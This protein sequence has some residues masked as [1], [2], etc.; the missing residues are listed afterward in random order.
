[1]GRDIFISHQSEFKPWV[2]WLAEA[3]QAQ[4]RTVFFDK[5]HLVAGETWVEGLDRGLQQARAAVLVATPEAVNSGWVR[6]EHA[7]LMSRCTTDPAFHYVPLVFGRFPSLPFLDTLHCVDC[8]E[9]SQYRDWFH[10]LC[11]GLDGV[12]PAD[13][14]A[15]YPGLK[16]PPAPA[17]PM[18]KAEAPAEV[19]FVQQ[20]MQQL[21]LATSPPVMVTSQGRRHQGAVVAMLRARAIER[22]GTAGVVHAVP[23]CSADAS[24]SAC[25]ADLGR[26]CKLDGPTPD[27]LSFDAAMERRIDAAGRLFLLLTG[28]ENAHAT[29]RHEL[30]ACLRTL[31]SHRPDDLRVALVGGERLVEQGFGNGQHSFLSGSRVMAWPHPTVADVMAWQSA[32]FPD[33][34]LPEDQAT[35]LLDATGGH[36]SLVRHGLE[37]WADR[38]PP[39]RWEDW[40]LACP[41]LWDSWNRLQR[42]A[43]DPQDLR[44]A[45]DRPQFGR[46]TLWPPDPLTRRLFWADLLDDR[47]GRLVWRCEVVRQV[48]REVL[49]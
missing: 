36:A 21:G 6:R 26:Q 22:Y 5:W 29:F 49:V 14:G 28:F 44:E 12:A 20:V 2:E 25:F 4:G 10:R 31:T 39:S 42:A 43:A 7:R 27:A 40:S 32:D 38:G 17:A 37:Q 8:R 3:L 48:G 41:E 33:A 45:L 15:D 30:A 13:R 47:A 1:M 19:K 9:P 23:P 35:A 46:A 34:A 18:R 11:C 16:P 24:I